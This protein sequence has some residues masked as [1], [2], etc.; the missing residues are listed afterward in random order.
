V[1][2]SSDY[3]LLVPWAIAVMGVG[4]LDEARVVVDRLADMGYRHPAL[5][6]VAASRGLGWPDATTGRTQGGAR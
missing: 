6:R 4:R 5:V 1:R 3:Q 2:G